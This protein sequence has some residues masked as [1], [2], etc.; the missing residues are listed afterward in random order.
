MSP[1]TTAAMIHEAV[2]SDKGVSG[3]IGGSPQYVYQL[4]ESLCV[5]QKQNLTSAVRSVRKQN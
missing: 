5:V 4:L 3:R 2:V 1:E